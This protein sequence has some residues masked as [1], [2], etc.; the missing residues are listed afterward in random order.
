M[1]RKGRGQGV[2][3]AARL[4]E[5]GLQAVLDVLTWATESDHERAVFLRERGLSLL[6]LMRP[7]NFEA[8]LGFARGPASRSRASPSSRGAHP[9]A[10][11]TAEELE[12]YE[13]FDP[14]T[15]V[16]SIPPSTEWQS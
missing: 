12:A 9:P 11:P 13:A 2:H 4:R 1:P 8:Y 16:A 14:D 5:H 3:L 15:P 7:A 6:T 10:E